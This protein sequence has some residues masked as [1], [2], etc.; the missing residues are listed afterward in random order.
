MRWVL[1]SFFTAARPSGFVTSRYRPSRCSGKRIQRAVGAVWLQCRRCTQRRAHNAAGHNIG[2]ANV[3]ATGRNTL[4]DGVAAHNAR[5]YLDA[6]I[7]AMVHIQPQ[8][9]S[10]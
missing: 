2:I 10:V 4:A 8:R 1:S 9:S 7:N 6:V 5:T 3:S